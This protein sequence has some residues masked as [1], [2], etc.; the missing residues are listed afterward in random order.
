MKILFF[1]LETTG[2][3]AKRH[4]IIEIAC[5]AE[6]DGQTLGD[7]KTKMRPHPGAEIDDA[8]LKIN[9][10]TRL[11][12]ADIERM[13]SGMAAMAFQ[14]FLM[15]IVD[16]YNKSDKLFLAGY[17]SASF[18]SPFLRAWL[19]RNGE[20][21]FGALF[22]WPSHDI[23]VIAQLALANEWGTLPNHKLATVAARFGISVSTDA[24]HGAAYDVELAKGI[25]YASMK[26]L[27]TRSA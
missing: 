27:K 5:I 18:D 16:R 6:K 21:Y 3:D 11:E 24:L 12:L 14:K 10:T 4:S 20:R 9:K 2:L 25:Y 22:H 26:L 17:N 15:Q 7:F 13:E 1:D 23:A 19:E 8:A